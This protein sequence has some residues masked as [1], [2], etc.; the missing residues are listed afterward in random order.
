MRNSVTCDH[1]M[2]SHNFQ[3]RN[4]ST[5]REREEAERLAYIPRVQVGSAISYVQDGV[6]YSA[7]VLS[8]QLRVE[9]THFE[10]MFLWYASVQSVDDYFSG[11]PYDGLVVPVACKM[12][13]PIQERTSYFVETVY[14]SAV[15]I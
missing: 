14:H 9:W 7:I 13:E 8:I 1:L 15:K 11:K 4:M 5:K 3:G 2:H 6:S 12:M 10:T